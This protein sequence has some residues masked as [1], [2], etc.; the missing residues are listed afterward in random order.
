MVPPQCNNVAHC[1]IVNSCECWI[2][3]ERRRCF[4][5]FSMLTSANRM[6][7]LLFLLQIMLRALL[8]EATPASRGPAPH[9]ILPQPQNSVG[10]C[11]SEFSS[12]RTRA[13]TSPRPYPIRLVPALAY[14]SPARIIRQQSLQLQRAIHC[15]SYWSK[16]QSQN[17]HSEVKDRPRQIQ[18]CTR[19]RH[20]NHISYR[21]A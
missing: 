9:T 1:Q 15:D 5:A 14:H 16:I 17:N 4:F 6:R 8:T 11:D 19:V 12:T 18:G 20:T 3:V 13:G 10:E 2:R 7:V 21:P